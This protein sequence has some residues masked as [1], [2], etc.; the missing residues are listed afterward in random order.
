MRIRTTFAVLIVLTVGTSTLVNLDR[1]APTVVE[2]DTARKQEAKALSEQKG[3]HGWRRF[4]VLTGGVDDA[5]G[6]WF[7]R[8]AKVDVLFRPEEADSLRKLADP[9]T[10]DAL[11]LENVELVD[12]QYIMNRLGITLRLSQE[13]DTR[14]RS[15]VRSRKGTLLFSP[16][17]SP[18]PGR[19]VKV[20][21]VFPE[22]MFR[23]ED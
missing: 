20:E 23:N 19:A 13:E 16:H 6:G 4:A 15:V 8:G 12:L 11:L 18:E 3:S 21:V 17:G 5:L 14:L 22:S 2:R 7:A 10:G 1:P 9:I